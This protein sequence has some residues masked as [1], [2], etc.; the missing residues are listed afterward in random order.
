[1]YISR[2][3]TTGIKEWDV[4]LTDN[5]DFN[6]NIL[7]LTIINCS[8]K[9]IRSQSLRINDDFLLYIKLVYM[10]QNFFCEKQCL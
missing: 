9:V 4:I 1:M 5:A 7:M 10:M 3:S 2:S 8:T 6:L